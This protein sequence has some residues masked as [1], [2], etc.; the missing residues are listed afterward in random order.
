MRPGCHRVRRCAPSARL[1][2]CC[3]PAAARPR[4]RS[5]S[6]CTAGWIGRAGRAGRPHTTLLSGLGLDPDPPMRSS[7]HQA[8]NCVQL[9][10]APGGAARAA[11][12]CTLAR[13]ERGRGAGGRRRLPAGGGRHLRGPRRPASEAPAW[14][15]LSARTASELLWR[16]LLLWRRRARHPGGARVGGA[17]PFAPPG[18]GDPP[19]PA[20]ARVGA[21]LVAL[22]A[23]H[24]RQ[25]AALVAQAE[26]AE[27]AARVR[28]HAAHAVGVRPHAAAAR[29][30]VAHA[31]AAVGATQKQPLAPAPAQRHASPSPGGGCA[32][33]LPMRTL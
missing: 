19:E 28:R 4:L 30:A 26:H 2:G 6:A 13:R 20:G 25:A 3:R 12:H 31:A 33:S 24:A 23:R 14:T 27:A 22:N 1:G 11:C 9:C 5:A 32:G 29:R 17:S 16:H 15:G 8:S 21:P 18:L 7:V 10:T